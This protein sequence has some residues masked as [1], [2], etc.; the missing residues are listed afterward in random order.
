MVF[1]S[2]EQEVVERATE[3]EPERGSANNMGMYGKRYIAYAH[4]EVF[5]TAEGARCAALRAFHAE[6]VL[7][8]DLHADF[9]CEVFPDDHNLRAWIEDASLCA[10][11]IHSTSI[12]RRGRENSAS[13]LAAN[14]RT[15]TG[16]MLPLLTCSKEPVSTRWGDWWQGC[17]WRI[18]SMTYFVKAWSSMLAAWYRYCGVRALGRIC[19]GGT[20]RGMTGTRNGKGVCV[21]KGAVQA[22]SQGSWAAVRCVR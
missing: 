19:T 16:S 11:I 21:M 15:E 2:A 7:C 12:S 4:V 8:V 1:E 17:G 13:R 14:S 18:Q 9:L 10:E 6:G 20:W 3:E 5:S 22:A